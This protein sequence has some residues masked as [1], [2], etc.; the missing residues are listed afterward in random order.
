MSLP[1]LRHPAPLK[2]V[3]RDMADH[4]MSPATTQHS[5]LIEKDQAPT[6]TRFWTSVAPPR[7]RLPQTPTKDMQTVTAE[8]I[9]KPMAL[10]PK[11]TCDISNLMSPPEAPR[12]ESFSQVEMAGM[13]DLAVV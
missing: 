8:R 7:T 9:A 2:T 10:E 4:R 13:G 6:T 3:I 12:L 5:V 11:K 1:S